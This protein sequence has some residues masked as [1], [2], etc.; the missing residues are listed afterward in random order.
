MSL[1]RDQILAVQ[2]RKLIEV[3]VPEWGGSVYLRTNS[4]RE[5]EEAVQAGRI[6]D[7]KI[8][9]VR[10]A[11]AVLSASICDEK[12]TR[13]FSP[14]DVSVLEGKSRVVIQRL[15]EKAQQINGFGEKAEKELEGNSPT[16]TDGSSSA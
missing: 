11:A 10:F 7:E 2:D 4:L 15:F 12:G 3:E 16:V 13:I 8:D 14:D 9:G 1:S 5:W 6:N